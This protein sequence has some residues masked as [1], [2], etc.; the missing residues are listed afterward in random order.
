MNA[1]IRMP[2]V[3]LAVVTIGCAAL[4]QRSEPQPVGTSG[5]VSDPIDV[6]ASARPNEVPVGQQLDVRLQSPLSSATAN[7]E[8]RF[9]ATT[10]VDVRQGEDVLIPAGAAVRGVVQGVDRATR[11]DRTASL[12]LSFDQITIRGREYRVR[13]MAT[14]VFRSEG[15][16][17]ETNR[18]GAGA[19]VGAVIGGILGGVRGALTGILIG[20]GGAILATEGKEVVL[21]AGTVVRIRFDSPLRLPAR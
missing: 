9:V 16:E 19:G 1:L 7:V 20:G 11:V 2:V 17:G 12:S 21:P 5:T 3:A 4:S 6:A 14:E 10:V 8:D 13:A 18:I 15:L